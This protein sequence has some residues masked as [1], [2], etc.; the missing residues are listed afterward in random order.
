MAARRV[1]SGIQPTGVLH[2]GNYLGA[3]KRWVS[4]Q[5][6][7]YQKSFY[8][9]VDLHALTTWKVLLPSHALFPWFTTL[10][11]DEVAVTRG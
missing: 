8:S 2:L 9:I 3:V 1:L 11:V 5:N 4:L 10:I 7:P 6:V